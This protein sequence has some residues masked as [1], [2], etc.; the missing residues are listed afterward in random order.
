MRTRSFFCLICLASSLTLVG[1]AQICR[2][3]ATLSVAPVGDGV[4]LLR[5]TALKETG[6]M[7]ITIT[8]DAAVLGNPHVTSGGLVVGALT[9]V[10]PNAPGV[11]RIMIIRTTPIQGSGIIATLTFDRK[12]DAVGKI[13]ALSAKLISLDNKPLPVLVRVDSPEKSLDPSDQPVVAVENDAKTVTTLTPAPDSVAPV[14]S[15]PRMATGIVTM[16]AAK[17]EAAERG[18]DAEVSVEEEIALTEAPT[19]DKAAAPPE[20]EILVLESVLDRFRDYE[21]ERTL[22]AFI[23]LFEQSGVGGFSQTPSPFLADGKSQ[24]KVDFTTASG[25]TQVAAITASGA[26]LLAKAQVPDN[27]LSWVVHLQPEKGVATASLTVPLKTFTI[28]FPLTVTPRLNIDLDKSGTVTPADFSLF[29]KKRL[30]L[31][32]DG[33]RDYRDDYHFTAN[34]LVALRGEQRAAT[35]QKVQ[36]KTGSPQQK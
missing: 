26:R 9:A 34:Y 25:D 21:G 18:I 31:N 23:A 8:Y 24:L 10:N 11:V 30:D 32:G 6:G 17:E 14:T 4:F 5:G 22:P 16:T 36:K 3:A 1:T 7:D 29:L 35:N 19:R 13:H 27:P 28:V 20:R 33:K 2:A 15:T 12:G